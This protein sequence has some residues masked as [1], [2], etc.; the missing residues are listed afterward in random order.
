M[1]DRATIE[2]RELDLPRVEISRSVRLIGKRRV[3]AYRKTGD[4]KGCV[5]QRGTRMTE[6]RSQCTSKLREVDRLGGGIEDVIG[7]FP[8]RIVPLDVHRMD[9]GP[10]HLLRR[11]AEAFAFAVCPIDALRGISEGTWF[12]RCGHSEARLALD[13]VAIARRPKSRPIAAGGADADSRRTGARAAHPRAGRTTSSKRV[14]PLLVAKANRA[15]KHLDEL[16]AEIDRYNLEASARPLLEQVAR[17]LA[18]RSSGAPAS[19]RAPTHRSCR[20]RGA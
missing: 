6:E 5:V 4:L 20:R 2:A 16:R 11:S 14:V 10:N 9:A 19:A 3:L 17:G 7:G 12:D 13:S 18:G 1:V 15:E 8:L